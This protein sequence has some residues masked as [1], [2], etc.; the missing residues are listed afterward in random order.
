MRRAEEISHHPAIR[1]FRHLASDV[2]RPIK[3]DLIHATESATSYLLKTLGSPDALAAILDQSPFG[4]LSSSKIA[5]QSE[6][7]G[8]PPGRG[9]DG[10]RKKIPNNPPLHTSS[11]EGLSHLDTP[12]SHAEHPA[13]AGEGEYAK[14]QSEAGSKQR[15]HDTDSPGRSAAM[16]QETAQGAKLIERLWKMF[17]SETGDIRGKHDLSGIGRVNKARLDLNDVSGPEKE[18]RHTARHLQ[19]KPLKSSGE[20]SALLKRFE[21]A[22][23]RTPGLAGPESHL[24][25]EVKSGAGRPSVSGKPS[26]ATGTRYAAR[27]QNAAQ[28]IAAQV[29][30]LW[31]KGRK[32]TVKRPGDTGQAFQDVVSASGNV[33]TR[34]KHAFSQEI[35]NIAQEAGMKP[36]VQR[37]NVEP[38]N[39]PA[40][41]NMCSRQGPLTIPDDDMLA[42]AINRQLIEQARRSGVEI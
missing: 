22:L 7:Q 42:E 34:G 13:H 39:A 19:E 3:R 17:Q 5:S 8:A 33:Y 4:A 10:K 14:D 16:S 38:A 2:A 37:E 40:P 18:L 27:P 24:D 20:A 41:S 25:M 23:G 31:K 12:G 6:A 15:A 32:T 26:M 1:H 29:E 21:H 35:Q 30:H 11:H 9:R 28:A 36:L